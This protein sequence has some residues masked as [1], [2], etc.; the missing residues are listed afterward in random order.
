MGICKCTPAVNSHESWEFLRSGADRSEAR[1][2]IA[3]K[4]FRGAR[5]LRPDDQPIRQNLRQSRA[6]DCLAR[7]VDIVLDAVILKRPPIAVED[8]ERRRGVAVAR[9][10]DRSRIDQVSLGGIE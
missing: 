6:Q 4:D 9:L 10:P 8:D 2:W 7:L 5:R 3:C 1:R